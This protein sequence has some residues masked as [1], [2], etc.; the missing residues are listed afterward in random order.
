MIPTK[1]HELIDWIMERTPELSVR[2]VED[3]ERLVD[4][5]M[6]ITAPVAF[7][8]CRVLGS[9]ARFWL[10]REKRYRDSLGGAN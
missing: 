6:Q 5:T 8:L 7:K 4:G 1:I 2:V 10:V 3:A 9:T